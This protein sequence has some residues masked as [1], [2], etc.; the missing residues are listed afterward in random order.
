MAPV[1]KGMEPLQGGVCPAKVGGVCPFKDKS[2][3]PIKKGTKNKPSNDVLFKPKEKRVYLIGTVHVSEKSARKV[4]ET[5]A[6]VL[7]DM[8][9]LELDLQ[10]FKAMQAQIQGTALN[11]QKPAAGDQ[12]GGFEGSGP[13]GGHFRY[14][15][16]ESP[17]TSFKEILTLPGLL[18]WLQQQ[19]GREFDVMPGAE[20]ASAYDTARRYKLNIGLIDRPINV[21]IARMWGTLPFKEKMKLLSY[22]VA[23]SGAF[24]LKPLFGGRMF[25]AQ[26]F[27]EGKKIDIG[28]LEK[29]EG[30]AD[31][32][33]LFK[34]QFPSLY[35]SLVG[36]RDAYMCDN[37]LRILAG[38]ANTLV[39]VVGM[40]H[41]TGMKKILEQRVKV[42]L[43]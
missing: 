13:E 28:K 6:M 41:A 35:R 37:I 18:K 15:S 30:M 27:G 10:R 14:S 26:V 23:A 5:I 33:S 34:E 7:P 12:K 39:V 19:I 11:E 9:C 42:E 31:L 24:F 22:V 3:C 38:G 21:T 4:E 36:E 40:G 17:P 32:M 29:G 1:T 43:V 16:W 8:V 20:L 25:G 2:E